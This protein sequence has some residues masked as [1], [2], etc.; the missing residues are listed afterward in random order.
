MLKRFIDSDVHNLP[1]WAIVTDDPMRV[2]M[3]VAHHLDNV[4]LIS[5][6]RGMLAYTGTIC[7]V[8]IGMY[9]VGFGETSTL[10]YLKEMID[11]G[12]TSVLYLGECVS[13][14]TELHL[15]EIVIPQS[16]CRGSITHYADAGL[17]E[18]CLSAAKQGEIPVRKM[19]IGTEDKYWLDHKKKG[20]HYR[21]T[22]FASGAV[23]EYATACG[24]TAASILTV[25]ENSLSG[26]R[27]GDA[28][29]QS[30]FHS[31]A[32]IAIV[33]MSNMALQPEGGKL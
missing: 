3:L 17:F 23:F 18:K 31:A 28:Q 5:E 32:K 6:N 24:L 20:E 29:R 8:P 33:L 16:A 25:S 26:Q 27:I 13:H 1:D 2:K 19:A 4:S 14:I 12:V 11:L 21:V 9:S 22:D 30:R 7:G 15:N 10:L